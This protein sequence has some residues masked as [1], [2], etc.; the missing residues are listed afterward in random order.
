[1]TDKYYWTVTGREA[2]GLQ[3]RG[4]YSLSF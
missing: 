3:I 1:L 4:S 2:V